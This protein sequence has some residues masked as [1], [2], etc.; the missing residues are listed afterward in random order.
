MQVRNIHSRLG[1]CALVLALAA[2]GT[3]PAAQAHRIPGVG[4]P[5]APSSNFVPPPRIIAVS[6]GDGFDFGA[7]SVGAG[8]AIGV[9]LVAAGSALLIKR[10]RKPRPAEPWTT[11]A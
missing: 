10:N 6:H 9:V 8:G 1:G 3:A 4:S 2:A 7:A 5:E 11:V